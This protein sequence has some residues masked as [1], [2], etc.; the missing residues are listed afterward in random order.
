MENILL[1]HGALGSS[2]QFEELSNELK[3]KYKVYLFDFNG[4]GS[5]SD[6]GPFTIK[7]FS[8]QLAKFINENDIKG[9]KV[10]GYSM[11]GYVALNCAVENPDL[12]SE[13][14]TLGTKFNWSIE[15]AEREV[16]MIQPHVIE[17]KVPKFAAYLKEVQLP[18]DWK[19][20][21]INTQA[22]MLNLGASPLLSKEALNKINIPVK[23]YRGQKDV[24]VTKE[25][26]LAIADVL[27]APYY[28]I[29]AMPHPIQMISVES[30]IDIIN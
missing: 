12:I 24:M 14:I 18:S 7:G 5:A 10:F 9:I 16:K 20:V 19:R 21:M 3:K 28:E 11:G 23:L 26:T 27:E 17:E 15:E 25:E 22:L 6:E 2:K 29:E 8:D 13:V 4:H 30:L 1:L